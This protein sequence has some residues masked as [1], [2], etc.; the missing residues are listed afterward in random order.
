MFSLDAKTPVAAA[1]MTFNKADAGLS[2]NSSA[3]FGPSMKNDVPNQNAAARY[4]K[5]L[6]KVMATVKSAIPPAPSVQ[7]PV[8]SSPFCLHLM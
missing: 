7:L 2:S 3:L 1:S 8:S 6:Q 5:A 4:K